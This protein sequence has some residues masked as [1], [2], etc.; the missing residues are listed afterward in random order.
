MKSIS[1]IRHIQ[2]SNR[3]LENRLLLEK[4]LDEVF[5]V[6]SDGS[7]GAAKGG[8]WGAAKGG[9]LGGE[10]DD[11]RREY[12]KQK[13]KEDQEDKILR[14]QVVE[15]FKEF[16]S[17]LNLPQ[18]VELKKKNDEIETYIKRFHPE[19]PQGKGVKIR[20]W[21]LIN[22]IAQ[23]TENYNKM[24]SRQKVFFIDTIN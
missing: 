8:S 9:S 23:E 5:A 3:I 2:E 4:Q 22:G 10:D 11:K 17:I 7:W 16:E 6:N 18:N 21:H 1:K 24:D 14:L 15:F 12:Y 20:K 13:E 19:S